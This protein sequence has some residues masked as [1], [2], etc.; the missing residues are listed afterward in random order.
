MSKKSILPIVKKVVEEF[1]SKSNYY[2]DKIHDEPDI[3]RI[4]AP[5]FDLPIPYKGVFIIIDDDVIALVPAETREVDNFECKDSGYKF[6]SSLTKELLTIKQTD[7]MNKAV[8]KLKD[9]IIRIISK[10]KGKGEITDENEQESSNSV[11]EEIDNNNTGFRYASYA[12]I[13]V[14]VLFIGV[15]IYNK[16]TTRVPNSSQD[17][18]AKPFVE[19]K[20]KNDQNKNGVNSQDNKGLDNDSA[21]KQDNKDGSE[22][23]NKQVNIPDG[24]SYFPTT[25]QDSN[26]GYT[27]TK[28]YRQSSIGFEH[29]P[30]Y[31]KLL[32]RTSADYTNQYSDLSQDNIFSTVYTFKSVDSAQK[33]L[34]K[35]VPKLGKV[36]QREQKN[37]E[38]DGVN[39]SHNFVIVTNKYTNNGFKTVEITVTSVFWFKNTPSLAF[40][41]ENWHVRR[42]KQNEVS[43]S[44][45]LK[46]TVIPDLN[47]KIFS[48]IVDYLSD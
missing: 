42:G 44:T 39:V 18:T 1:R 7:G 4:Y 48:N 37:Y 38:I 2:V 11:R 30:Y 3:W 12:V 25:I 5:E 27:R 31:N 17:V 26:T 20:N 8:S 32:Y 36:R 46:K 35:E 33:Y 40:V 14:I 9:K 24:K 15:V 23:S 10:L 47:T 22:K 43:L 13:A 21:D 45:M 29:A 19:D 34:Q 16:I 41:V 6:D 28:T